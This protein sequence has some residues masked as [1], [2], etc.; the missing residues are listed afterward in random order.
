VSETSGHAPTSPGTRRSLT[1][2]LSRSTLSF[3]GLAILAIVVR[4]E[5]IAKEAGGLAA[6]IANRGLRLVESEPQL[7]H[8][9][10]RP[11]PSL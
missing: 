10:P 5:R 2:A 11:R 6:G 4:A 9:L 3:D 1:L 8:H 7:G